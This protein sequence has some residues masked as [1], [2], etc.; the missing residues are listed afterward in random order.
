MLIKVRIRKGSICLISDGKEDVPATFPFLFQRK[1]AKTAQRGP[2]E[3][4]ECGEPMCA[5]LP[6][7]VCVLKHRPLTSAHPYRLRT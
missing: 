6:L 4:D 3:S 5:C 7:C 2:R 1:E